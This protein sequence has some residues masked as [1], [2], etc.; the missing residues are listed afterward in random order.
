MCSTTQTRRVLPHGWGTSRGR[1]GGR[2]AANMG[3]Q[4]KRQLRK[5]GEESVMVASASVP[6]LVPALVPTRPTALVV[7][8]PW[9]HGTAA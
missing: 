9:A 6:A 2:A 4:V 1:D 8:A 5:Q 7:R 3:G